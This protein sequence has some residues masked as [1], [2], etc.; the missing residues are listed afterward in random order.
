DAQALDQC[1]Q[2]NDISGINIEVDESKTIKRIRVGDRYYLLRSL[3]FDANDQVTVIL[4]GNA[5]E[6]TFPIKMYRN[7]LVNAEMPVNSTQFRA[8]DADAGASV[9]FSE[10]FGDEFDFSNYK[11]LMKS[12]NGIDPNSSTDEDALFV[13]CALWGPTGD[14]YRVGYFYPTSSN[15]PI[16]SIVSVGEYVNVDIFLKSGD[17]VANNIDG[18]TEWDVTIAP[19]SASVDL[20]TYS[21]NSVGTNPAMAG[22]Q[23]GHYVTINNAGEFDP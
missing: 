13:R 23:P 3:D 14:R 2:M 15:Q 20:V 19:E 6:Q 17:P 10:F 5:S 8:Y 7:A 12:R 4:D 18:T 16:S 1:V 9:N 21:W 11:V 22:L